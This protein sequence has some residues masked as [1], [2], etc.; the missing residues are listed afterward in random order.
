MYN[1]STEMLRET[2]YD[3]DILTAY[4]NDNEAKLTAEQRAV[5]SAL[6]D[7]VQ[8]QEAGICFLDAPGGTGKTFLLSLLLAKV[9]QH[10]GIAIAVASSGIAATLLP[11][12]RTAHS[13]FKLLLD[14]DTIDAPVCS[15]AK[16]SGTGQVL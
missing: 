9:R 2:S 12:G 13:A 1:L 10:K 11:G 7:R 14:L 4:I 16:N 8:Q 15:I 5:Y 3:V 6:F